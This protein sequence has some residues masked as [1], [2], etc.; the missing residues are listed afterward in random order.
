MKIDVVMPSKT[1]DRLIPMIKNCINSLRKAEPLVEFNV[2]IVESG[3]PA[4]CGQ[5]ETIFYESDNFNYNHALNLGLKLCSHEWVIL[6]NNDL[7][8]HEHFMFEIFMAH[9]ER[10][11][12][13][14]F[15]PWNAMYG[16]HNSYFPNPPKIIEGYRICAEL[17]GWC[18]IAK[19]EIFKIVQLKEHVNFWYSDN[20]YADALIEA[21]IKHALVSK[22]RV[23]HLTSKTKVVSREEAQHS[24]NLYLGGLGK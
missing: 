22:S 1:S 2:I 18:I 8:F 9:A 15:S 23:D 14:S 10:P 13:K 20:V 16:W 4:D 7:M 21:G 17:V 12:I 5:D 19:R 24:L 11:D 3:T 6:A